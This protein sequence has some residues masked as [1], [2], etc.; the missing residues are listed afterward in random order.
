MI[1]AAGFVT[2]Q[3]FMY[4]ENYIQLLYKISGEKR[5]RNFCLL[6]Q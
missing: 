5:V 3:R 4:Q 1:S 6:P 2:L